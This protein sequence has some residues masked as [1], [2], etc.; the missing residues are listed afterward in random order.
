MFW[1]RT[2]VGGDGGGKPTSCLKLVRINYTDTISIKGD[3]KKMKDY[4]ISK[5]IVYARKVNICAIVETN[6]YFQKIC[7]LVP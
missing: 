7:I 1:D 2:G 5:I 6:M 4:Q 3:A